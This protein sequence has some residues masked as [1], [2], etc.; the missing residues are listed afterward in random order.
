MQRMSTLVVA[1]LFAIAACGG[2]DNSPTQPS[3][4]AAPTEQAPP[5][6]P[7]GTPMTAAQCT[8]AGG[9]VVGD[10]GDGA[11][12]RPDYRCPQSGEPPLG[13][14]QSEAGEPVAIEGAVCC[15]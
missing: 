14:I 11:I 9:E 5:S 1:T 3:P 7:S 8:A 13:P 15:K 12:H 2:K 4:P 10:I 6:R